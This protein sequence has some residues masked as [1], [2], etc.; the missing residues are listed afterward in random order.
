M[1]SG[2]AQ[3]NLS[4]QF[5]RS[6]FLK[7]MRH[8]VVERPPMTP[9]VPYTSQTAYKRLPKVPICTVP[10]PHINNPHDYEKNGSEATVLRVQ[11]ILHQNIF[12]KIFPSYG[13]MIV[14]FSYFKGTIDSLNSK[15][16]LLKSSQ[17]SY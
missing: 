13:T 9:R 1:V 16:D 11:Y 3:K 5:S 17:Y 15:Q 6:G 8:L 10:K 14:I 12:H 7:A 2:W 4:N